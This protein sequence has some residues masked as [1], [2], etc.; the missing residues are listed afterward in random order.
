MYAEGPVIGHAPTVV[1]YGNEF[2]IRLAITPTSFTIAKVCLIRP[3]AVSHGFDQNQRR[4]PLTFQQTGTV[5]QVTAPP[6]GNYAPPGH[7]M[8]F[9]VDSNGVPSIARYLRITTPTG[10]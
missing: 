3:A 10:P 1:T 6:S 7:Y 4:V 9:V 2:S 8:L 5:L